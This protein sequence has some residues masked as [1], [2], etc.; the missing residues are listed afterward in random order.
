MEPGDAST[1]AYDPQYAQGGYYETN[2]PPPQ[3]AGPETAQFNM[4]HGDDDGDDD[5]DDG[6]GE[7]NASRCGV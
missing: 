5:D 3:S 2:A 6:P 1:A 4:E 7:T